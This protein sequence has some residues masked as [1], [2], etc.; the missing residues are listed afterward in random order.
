MLAGPWGSPKIATSG[1]SVNLEKFPEFCGHGDL[2]EHEKCYDLWG[3]N[4]SWLSEHKDVRRLSI[5]IC[6][7]KPSEPKRC[8]LF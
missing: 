4:G 6:I 5:R 7:V 3:C 2:V 8:R 1:F